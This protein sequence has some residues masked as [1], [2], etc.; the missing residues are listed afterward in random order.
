MQDKA[1][2]VV[3]LVMGIRRLMPRIGT[4]KLYYLLEEPL[5]ALGV[6]RDKLF[7][8]LR[9]NHMLIV[10][11]RQYRQTTNS[12]HMFRKHKNLVLDRI[13]TRP[14]EIWVSDITYVGARNKHTYL[15]LVTDA[16]S[17]KIVGYDL[18]DSLAAEGAIRA[19]QMACRGRMYKKQPLI[20]HSD[21]GI[22]YCC[23]DYQRQLKEHHIQVSM[24]ESYDPYANAVAERINATIKHEFLL[25]ELDCDLG[26]QQRIVA[27]SV[28]IYNELR[29]HLSCGMLTPDEMHRQCKKEIATYRTKND[30]TARR[31]VI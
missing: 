4:R 28:A 27:Q 30:N 14:E 23:D 24:T 12:K 21:R 16:Y 19:L 2:E 3:S 17:K 26:T 29:P 20:H 6:G 1:A 11:K 15:A 31:V 13:P 10:P 25:E 18:S 7:D 22:Q 9:A 8:V 5:T